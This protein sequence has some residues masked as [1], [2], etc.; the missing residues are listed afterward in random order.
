M[1][2]G[3]CVKCGKYTLIQRH[4]I[5]PKAVFGEGETEDLCPN[6][7]VEYHHILGRDLQDK[8]MEFH[9]KKYYTWLYLGVVGIIL[10]ILSSL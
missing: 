9:F 5:L 3:K 1:K 8:S 2:R 10:F 6:C 7:H 4:H